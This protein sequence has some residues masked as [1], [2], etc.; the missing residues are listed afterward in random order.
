[1]RIA[2]GIPLYQG[3]YNEAVSPLLELVIHTLK[4]F[5]GSEIIPLATNR[6]WLPRARINI[7]RRARREK[8]DYLFWVG[9]DLVYSKD[10]ILKLLSYNHP[11]VCGLYFDRK[12]PYNPCVHK[13]TNEG[14]YRSLKLSEL[15]DD[16][17][18]DAAGHDCMLVRADILKKIDQETYLGQ[19]TLEG[20]D[21]AFGRWAKKE[22]I[23]IYLSTKVIPGHIVSERQ[24]IGKEK[25]SNIVDYLLQKSTWER[26]R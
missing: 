25:A 20:D 5:P 9:E 3:L 4:A 10:T 6:D 22:G 13:L 15:A 24:I 1:M 2:I 12:P 19:S 21:L 26:K 17:I 14:W 18:V 23:S 7:V 16:M 11:V 8:V